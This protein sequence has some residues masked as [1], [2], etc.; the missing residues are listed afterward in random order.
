MNLFEARGFILVLLV[1]RIPLDDFP[2]RRLIELKRWLSCFIWG[3]FGI[4]MNVE[5]RYIRAIAW[6]LHWPE[7]SERPLSN[8]IAARRLIV[9]SPAVVMFFL[10]DSFEVWPSSWARS[11]NLTES[12]L[13]RSS[14][15]SLRT[16]DDCPELRSASDSPCLTFRGPS[17]TPLE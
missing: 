6:Y 15:I 12:S 14:S 3:L 5:F 16:R 2:N 4:V 11:I 9:G 7:S 1:F 17:W 13:S 8:L 10:W